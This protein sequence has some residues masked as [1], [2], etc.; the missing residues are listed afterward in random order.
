M[1]KEVRICP[2][3]DRAEVPSLGKDEAHHL[4]LPVVVSMDEW[5]KICKERKRIY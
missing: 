5:C 4:F 2:T 3:E 1:S